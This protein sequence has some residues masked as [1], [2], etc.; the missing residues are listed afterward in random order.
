[1]TPLARYLGPLL[2]ALALLPAA[3][4]QPAIHRCGTTISDRK[5]AAD[6]SPAE[7][8]ARLE[9]AA[10]QGEAARLAREAARADR[11]LVQKYPNATAHG[12]AR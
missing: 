10:V 2:L 12:E 5:C 8:D 7:R 3:A 6:E 4:Q 9:A 1:M 11:A